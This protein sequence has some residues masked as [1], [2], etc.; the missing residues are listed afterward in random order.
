MYGVTRVAAAYETIVGEMGWRDRRISTAF[1]PRR[2]PELLPALRLH[3][4]QTFMKIAFKDRVRSARRFGARGVSE[5]AG[6]RRARRRRRAGS[7]SSRRGP[8]RALAERPRPRIYGKVSRVSRGDHVIRGREASSSSMFIGMGW[9]HAD[10]EFRV[11]AREGG[12]RSRDSPWRDLG[13]GALVPFPHRG[14]GRGVRAL[15]VQAGVVA[16]GLHTAVSGCGGC[17]QLPRRRRHRG[18]CCRAQVVAIR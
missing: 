7:A 5:A 3:R 18:A 10:F 15:R 17:V 8:G 12:G 13:V 1:Q 11:I 6:G 9:F 16:W 14:T 2:M 4:C